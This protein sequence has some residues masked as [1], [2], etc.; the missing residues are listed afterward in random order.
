MRLALYLCLGLLAM[1]AFSSPA[2]T[3]ILSTID[4]IA[5]ECNHGLWDT[6]TS[7]LKNILTHHSASE[8]IIIFIGPLC[9]AVGFIWAGLIFLIAL[10]A[11]L[12][13]LLLAL[14]FGALYVVSH[15]EAARLSTILGALLGLGAMMIL[16]IVRRVRL[17]SQL[18]RLLRAYYLPQLIPLP[19]AKHTPLSSEDL[20]P[21]SEQD[22]FTQQVK[23]VAGFAPELSDSMRLLA[24]QA[25][26]N[27]DLSLRRSRILGNI[28]RLCWHAIARPI[29]C[30]LWGYTI[31]LSDLPYLVRALSLG[32]QGN[33]TMLR[34]LHQLCSAYEEAAHQGKYNAQMK[35]FAR[36]H[37]TK[38]SAL[39]LKV[40]LRVI[41]AQLLELIPSNLE[42]FSAERAGHLALIDDANRVFSTEAVLKAWISDQDRT[43]YLGA[44]DY[45]PGK[46]YTHKVKLT[47]QEQHAQALRVALYHELAQKL[48]AGHN[49]NPPNAFP[50]AR[51]RLTDY[52]LL[53]ISFDI[54]PTPYLLKHHSAEDK[55]VTEPSQVLGNKA[56][57]L[58]NAAQVPGN[59]AQVLGN[60]GQVLGN[61]AEKYQAAAPSQ[62]E[63][64]TEAEADILSSA[65]GVPN[66]M[67][68]VK[69]MGRMRTLGLVR[70]LTPLCELM[71]CLG[72]LWGLLQSSTLNTL[73]DFQA[74]HYVSRYAEAI[75]KSVNELLST[76]DAEV[77]LFISHNAVIGIS[78]ELSNLPLPLY[79]S[80]LMSGYHLWL[81]CLLLTVALGTII[82]ISGLIGALRM[83]LKRVSAGLEYWYS[84]HFLQVY[85]VC[86]GLFVM[87][88]FAFTYQTKIATLW[89]D[90]H[91]DLDLVSSMLDDQ[92]ELHD[93]H[94]KLITIECLINRNADEHSI[95]PNNEVKTLRRLGLYS[96][97]T[98]HRWISVYAPLHSSLVAAILAD[99]RQEQD[100]RFTNDKLS[101]H[102]RRTNRTVNASIEPYRLTFTP[103]MHIVVAIEPIAVN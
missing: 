94:D 44:K 45:T 25:L 86:T 93:Y 68:T 102:Q 14:F 69:P 83:L 96:P 15:S 55:A 52:E 1:V 35:R 5:S 72:V 21:Q 42:L 71:A 48:T 62:Q 75:G 58:G 90:I 24:L 13:V 82:M 11:K 6:I 84:L 97:Q 2:Y 81:L 60:E 70:L 92:F 27:S 12:K 20:V 10:P 31:A 76:A 30:N 39:A 41:C 103:R 34:R 22:N 99:I 100:R 87:L 95:G 54:T 28:R 78:S 16:I 49:G 59:E 91:R 57:V 47:A 51:Q 64:G 40:N 80:A 79:S 89:Y 101:Y 26:N 61:A 32:T 77:G 65:A 4:L 29:C 18:Q 63:A 88:A 73:L 23:D 85:G 7:T 19:Q 9:F 17:V 56:Q 74:H 43:R 98:D 67:L 38:G 50:T 66:A 3:L 8:L 36:N 33:L 46:W 37:L 53:E